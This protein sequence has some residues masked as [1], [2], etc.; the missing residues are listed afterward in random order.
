M[1]ATQSS[2]CDIVVL[3]IVIQWENMVLLILPMQPEKLMLPLLSFGVRST[4]EL[5]GLRKAAR[6]KMSYFV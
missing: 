3:S 5:S 6:P 1:R 2:L 4:G